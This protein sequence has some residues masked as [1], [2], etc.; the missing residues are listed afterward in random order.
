MFM[1]RNT[2]DDR[3]EGT[4]MAKKDEYILLDTEK[5]SIE[6]A[7][8]YRS[9]V[10]YG[11][12][13][14]SDRTVAD[15][16]PI[17]R[18]TGDSGYRL[19]PSSALG[20]LEMTYVAGKHKQL[21]LLKPGSGA[22]QAKALAIIGFT[23]CAVY[24]A[25]PSRVAPLMINI[26]DLEAKSPDMAR[27]ALK[28]LNQYVKTNY[29]TA[30]GY[31]TRTFYCDRDTVEL[32]RKL[33]FVSYK[34]EL[35]IPKVES[36]KSKPSIA[37]IPCLTYRW[38]G[39]NEFAPICDSTS[40]KF[41][42]IPSRKDIGLD[43]IM[44]YVRKERAKLAESVKDLKLRKMLA[45]SDDKTIA[46]LILNNRNAWYFVFGKSGIVAAIGTTN[47]PDCAYVI[48]SFIVADDCVPTKDKIRTKFTAEM[49]SYVSTG[50]VW[51]SSRGY[52][53]FSLDDYACTSLHRYF[54]ISWVQTVASMNKL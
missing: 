14:F 2:I 47:A 13:I 12:P 54:P 34:T 33:N 37:K 44:A 21:F 41:I 36:I 51:V 18:L 22:K 40:I 28:M 45:Y 15:I 31:Y 50:N 32:V 30:L 49:C 42:R 10:W 1:A 9:N 23:P 8:A 48:E 16:P 11:C 43:F 6:E 4:I 39:R 52:N 24:T 19:Y 3:M 38:V 25:D 29:P 7:S 27:I 53:N 5:L 26:T 35:P 17:R 46:E 20:A